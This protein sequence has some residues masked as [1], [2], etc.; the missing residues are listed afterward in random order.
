MRLERVDD[1]GRIERTHHR[2]ALLLDDVALDRQGEPVRMQ[3][4]VH[5]DDAVGP[6]A[7]STIQRGPLAAGSLTAMNRTIGISR[8]LL[9]QS[10][11]PT[12]SS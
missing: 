12:V 5:V 2:P 7:P 4:D 10:A 1:R 6:H 9:S 8:P 11:A 3:A